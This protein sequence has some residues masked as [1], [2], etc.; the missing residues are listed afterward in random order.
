MNF[1][2]SVHF[3]PPLDDGAAEGGDAAA[4]NDAAAAETE[5]D[6]ERDFVKGDRLSEEEREDDWDKE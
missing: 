4:A 2:D 3:T 1:S 5:E 6:C